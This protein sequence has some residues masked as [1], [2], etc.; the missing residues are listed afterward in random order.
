MYVRHFV[1]CVH[2]NA[3][4][5][6]NFDTFNSPHRTGLLGAFINIHDGILSTGFGWNLALPGS[7]DIGLSHLFVRQNF[8]MFGVIFFC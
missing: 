3:L 5:L 6:L 8:P 2:R 1:E 7:E 4:D